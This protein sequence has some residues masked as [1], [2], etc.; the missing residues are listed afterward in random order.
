MFN[1]TMR[2]GLVGDNRL[3]R[4]F[5]LFCA[6]AMAVVCT[7]TV[8]QAWANIYEWA[9]ASDRGKGVV[10]S[11]T[12]CPDGSGVSAEPLANLADLDLTQAY[13]AGT[14]LF[15]ANLSGANL[16]NAYM[17]NL[18]LIGTDL[19]NANLSNANLKWA[20]CG[21]AT[22]TNA[23]LTNANL[24]G[25]SLGVSSLRGAVM[26]GAV[27]TG[28]NF[29]GT[30][31]V[32][33]T[34]GQLYS[35]ASYQTGDLSSMKLN[36]NN[37]TGW[38]FAGQNLNGANLAFAALAY[39]NLANTNFYSANL[40]TVN[41]TGAD[42]RGAVEFYASDYSPTINTI[43]PDGTIQGLKLVANNPSLTIRNYSGNIPI[44]ILETLSM[45]RDT[46]LVF[47]ID[48]NPWGSTISFDAGI[49]VALGG[50]IELG[51]A[52]GVDPPSLMGGT[53]HLFDWMSV[54]PSG[55]FAQVINNLSDG[56]SWDISQLYTTGSV[57]LIPEPSTLVLLGIGTIGLLGFGWLRK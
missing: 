32:G 21:D 24:V 44:H 15:M 57:T 20:Q 51:L 10:Q 42:A 40:N 27:V 55:Q 9:W 17:F 39:A 56:Y 36:D 1:N 31:D 34:A 2:R 35:T 7:C 28:A 22:F 23:N 8:S 38:S 18:A 50:N 5:A 14:N 25:A 49:P 53:I 43:L 45:S 4:V 3:L 52:R 41:F 33:F 12:L 30:T 37:M 29:G 19:T 26:R 6:I 54:S 48:G 47:Q 11:T 16:T 46:S 13:L